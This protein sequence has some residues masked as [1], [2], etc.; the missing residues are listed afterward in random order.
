MVSTISTQLSTAVYADRLR[1]A[2][3][4]RHGRVVNRSH[5][6]SPLWRAVGHLTARPGRESSAALPG[7]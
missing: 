1:E 6:R 2:A 5:G 4:H 3:Q 7:W